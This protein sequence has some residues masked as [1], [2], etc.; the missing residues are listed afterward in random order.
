[1]TALDSQG[2]SFFATTTQATGHS[3]FTVEDPVTGTRTVWNSEDKEA[4]VLTFPTAVAGRQSCWRVVQERRLLPGEP[5]VGYGGINCPPAERHQGLHCGERGNAVEPPPGDSSEAKPSYEECS[6]M[7]DSAIISGTLWE[8]NEDLGVATILGVETHDCRSTVLASDGTHMR[9][10]WY[11]KF[12]TVRRN[13]GLPLRSAD[14]SPTHLRQT[15]PTT[16][17]AT[18]LRFDEPDA[19]MF[20]PPA[21]T[22]SRR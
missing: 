11:T 10:M 16:S 7:L 6:R 2:R 8:K 1:M 4:K 21:I 13:V 5:Q 18:S 12:G 20:H 3:S 14:E 15:V 17:E 9:E 22:P 19:E